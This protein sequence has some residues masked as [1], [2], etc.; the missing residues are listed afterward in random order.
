M[1]LARLLVHVRWVMDR[2]NFGPEEQTRARE[3]G[4]GYII[5]WAGQ[6]RVTAP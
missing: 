5:F 4:G 1:N 3:R 2:P 6:A